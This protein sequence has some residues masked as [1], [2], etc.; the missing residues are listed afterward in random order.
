MKDK[1]PTDKQRIEFAKQ[2]EY[3]YEIS[4]PGWPKIILFAFV[5]G[6]ATAL[7]VLIGGTIVVAL[8]LWLLSVLGHVPLLDEVIEPARESIQQ[9]RD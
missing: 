7:G 6:M 1:Q 5:K 4:Q 8:L 9:G 2:L 3:M